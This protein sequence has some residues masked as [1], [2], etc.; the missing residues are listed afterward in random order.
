MLNA[1]KCRV[2]HQQEKWPCGHDEHNNIDQT[3]A[4]ITSDLV[5]STEQCHS[6]GK[7]KMIYSAGQ[8]LVVEYATEKSCRIGRWSHKFH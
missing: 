4:D 8:F 6:L 2:Q 7:R 1:T 3:V 5:I